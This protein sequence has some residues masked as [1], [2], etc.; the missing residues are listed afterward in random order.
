V[1]YPAHSKTQDVWDAFLAGRLPVEIAED[2]GLA[3]Q[4]VYNLITKG[5]RHGVLAPTVK[6]NDPDLRLK[7]ARLR[8]GMVCDIIRALSEDQLSWIIQQCL[9]MEIE[10]VAEYALELI[11]DAYEEARTTKGPRTN[12]RK[13]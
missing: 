12:G 6:R 5:R 8:S 11:R 4:T 3:K 7:R 13:S 1:A 2:L 9:T 10:S